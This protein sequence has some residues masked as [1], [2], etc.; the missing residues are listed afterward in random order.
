[1]PSSL[2]FAMSRLQPSASA[3]GSLAS[4]AP[5]EGCQFAVYKEHLSILTG[6]VVDTTDVET[7]V[8]L[9]EGCLEVSNGSTGVSRDSRQRTIALD[10]D[11]C[12]IGALLDRGGRGSSNGCG[13][14]A[15]N[16]SNGEALHCDGC[17]CE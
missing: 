8:A 7:L 9:P 17:L 6:L 11:G 14:G 10:G 3:M 16:G 2:N 4:D 1:M 15:G 12:D 13:E 5:P